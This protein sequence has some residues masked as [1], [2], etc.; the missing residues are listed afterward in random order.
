MPPKRTPRF[1]GIVRR[2]RQRQIPCVNRNEARTLR[3]SLLLLPMF[4]VGL[5]GSTDTVDPPSSSWL[6][7]HQ[8]LRPFGR[9]SALLVVGLHLI[10]WRGQV[11]I[12]A[13]SVA[14]S[15]D[16]ALDNVLLFRRSAVG[17][18]PGQLHWDPE[19]SAAGSGH[20]N[21]VGFDLTMQTDAGATTAAAPEPQHDLVASDLR[22]F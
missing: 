5:Y 10:S 13:C 8:P 2:E 18:I 14:K 9:S 12:D 6:S 22:G 3:M 1:A 11:R 21:S 17:M 19:T 16:D 4:A 15:L 7:L 20:G